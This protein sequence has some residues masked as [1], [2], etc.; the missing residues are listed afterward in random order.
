MA[1]S[2]LLVDANVHLAALIEQLLHDEP[3]FEVLGVAHTAD[4]AL[5]RVRRDRPDVVLVDPKLQPGPP[6]GLCAALH[7]ASPHVAVLL[8]VHA[9]ESG[10]THEPHVDGTLQ[11]G[12]TFRDLVDAV[13]Q[14]KADLTRR[15]VDLT[16][17]NMGSTRAPT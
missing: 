12:M 16:R 2:V 4:E 5:T 17:R 6:H 1:T 14:A 9:T 10:A 11:R 8:W 7:D 13:T 15:H 3:D